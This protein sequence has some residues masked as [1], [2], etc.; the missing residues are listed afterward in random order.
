MHNLVIWDNELPSAIASVAKEFAKISMA[1]QW[2]H[3]EKLFYFLIDEPYGQDLCQLNED[4]NLPACALINLPKSKVVKLLY[5]PKFRA[6]GILG[7]SPLDN[8]VLAL[9]GDRNKEMGI[10]KQF[11]FPLSI[12]NNIGSKSMT[13]ENFSE[14]ATASGYTYTY[15]L[16]SSNSLWNKEAVEVMQVAPIPPYP[17]MC[18]LYILC[19]I[20]ESLISLCTELKIEKDF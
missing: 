2:D 5:T 8:K 20:L 1:D 13:Q 9:T 12:L 15:P 4:I 16:K 17:F 7:N 6:S 19:T 14:A 10:P 18:Q 3:A 11:V